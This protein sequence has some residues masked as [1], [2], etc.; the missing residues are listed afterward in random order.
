MT[1]FSMIDD[2]FIVNQS[3]GFNVAVGLTEYDNDPSVIEDA[4]YATLVVKNH[5]WGEN[6]GGMVRYG[7]KDVS[8]HRCSPEE[9]GLNGVDNPNNKFF[10]SFEQQRKDIAKY[11]PKLNCLNQDIDIYG[12][13]NSQRGSTLFLAVEKCDPSKRSTCKNDDEISKWLSNKFVFILINEIV[14]HPDEYEY[15]GKIEKRSS[16]K[17]F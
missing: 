8:T 16:L 4:D 5:K 14:F 13:Y 10:P 11:G 6:E 3:T 15:P 1:K 17:W 12:N 2:T 9:I 7:A